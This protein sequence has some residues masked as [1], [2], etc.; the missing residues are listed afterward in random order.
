VSR[1]IAAWFRQDSKDEAS[2]YPQAGADSSLPGFRQV[3]WRCVPAFYASCRRFNPGAT[4]RFYT[5][6]ELP[7]I[8][9]VSLKDLLQVLDV[10]VLDIPYTHLPPDGYFGQWRNQFFV[11]DILQDLAL[12]DFEAAIILDTDCVFTGPADALF[13]RVISDGAATYV[14]APVMANP[15]AISNGLT[16]EQL[17]T[18]SSAVTGKPLRVSYCGGEIVA[19]RGDTLA[20]VA[21]RVQLVWQ[22]SQDRNARGELKFNEEAQLLS[23]IYAELG[24]PVGG[25]DP[26][27]RRIWTQRAR[28]VQRVDAWRPI[29]HLPGEKHYGFRQ[30][31]PYIR[32]SNSWFWA[33]D[34][35]AFR[36]R[37]GRVMSI[38]RREPRKWVLDRRDYVRRKVRDRMSERIRSARG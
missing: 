4:L 9:G 20:A 32:N 25:A 5:N 23:C 10:E 6:A 22:D 30:L 12:G 27:I 7:T 13:D 36:E 33:D 8:D 19:L 2:W 37:L 26:F 15:L 16:A 31:I 1:V 21:D 11:L 17:D 34:D 18:L 24:L 35:D 29:W 3:Y 38:P 28:D 14:V